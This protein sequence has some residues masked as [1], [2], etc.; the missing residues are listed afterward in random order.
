M[1]TFDLPDVRRFADD[2]DARLDRCDS[3]EGT[4]CATL[5]ASLTHYS[6][7]CCQFMEEVRRWGEEVFIGRVAFDPKVEREWKDRGVRLYHR[8]LGR[9]RLGQRLTGPCHELEG[10]APLEGAILEL[11][12]LLTGWVT[13]KRAV[14]PAARLGDS[15]PSAVVEEARRRLAELPQLPADWEPEDPSQRAWFRKLRSS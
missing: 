15:L 8:A 6:Q 9:R 14:S 5:D 3:G 12:E 4:E 10:L 13:P 2:L 11:H 7:L 1:T